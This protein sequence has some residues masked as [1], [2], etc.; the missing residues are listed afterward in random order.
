[1]IH[2][3]STNSCK[4]IFIDRRNYFENCLLINDF[5]IKIIFSWDKYK[6]RGKE[7]LK[8]ANIGDILK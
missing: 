7:E 5:I 6:Y 2:V 4:I 8:L 3:L 1:M